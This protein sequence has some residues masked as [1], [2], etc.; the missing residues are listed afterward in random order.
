MIR[1]MSIGMK[2]F[3]AMMA[4]SIIPVIIISILVGIQVTSLINSMAVSIQQTHDDMTTE[5][6]GANLQGSA[7]SAASAMDSFLKERIRDVQE[8]AVSPVVSEATSTAMIIVRSEQLT[9]KSV[10]EIETL[11]KDKRAILM[12]SQYTRFL[13]GLLER[14]PEFSE[15]F[16]TDENGF[17]VSYSNP[18]SD[19]VQSDEVWWQKA[20]QEGSYV[21]QVSYDE[22]SQ[23]YSVEIA[24]R[25]N[26]RKVDG[27]L[28]APLGVMK[29][30]LNVTEF[31]KIA[32]SS[33]SHLKQG[34][35]IVFTRDGYTVIDTGSSDDSAIMSDAGNVLKRSWNTAAEILS[36]G[37]SG[38]LF[39]QKS[40]AGESIDLGYASTAGE[41]Y[42]NLPGF[43]GPQWYVVIQQPTSVSQASLARLKDEVQRIEGFRNNMMQ[44]FV[45]LILV[46]TLI[47]VFLS[48]RISQGIV[49]PI[50]N[51]VGL[52]QRFS[53]GDMD[54]DIPV[55]H[56]NEIGFLERA[57]S[58]MVVQ[59]RQMLQAERT[60]REYMENSVQRY[61]GYM[62]KVGAGNLKAA[63]EIDAKGRSENDPLVRLGHNLEAMTQNLRKTILQI[64]EASANLAAAST[65]ILAA[66]TQQ[67]SGAAEQ[68]AAISQTTTTV[69]EVK[70]IAEQSS[71]RAN[72]VVNA[73]KRTEMVSI[74]GQRSVQNT[75]ESMSQ[76][77]G[78]VEGIAENILALSEQTQQIGEII[79]T[80]NE[81]A[82]QSNMLALNAS[83][84]AARAGEHGKGFAVVA[85]EV[86]SL[87]EQSRSATEQ[88]K[89][90]LSEIQKATN[91]TVMATEEGTKGVD[92][93]VSLAAQAQA[94]LE[95]LSNVIN[96]ASSSARQMAASGQQQATGV[97]QVVLAMRNINQATIQSLASTRQA[98]KAA[99]NLNELSSQ[100]NSMV[101][102]YEL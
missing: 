38:F 98:E 94:A 56:E 36:L 39:D 79:A 66:T 69:D 16:F 21:G 22:S 49:R 80:V 34:K 76:I 86:R 54:V 100:L 25:F 19:F 64:R 53:Q 45:V 1:R 67:A 47:A 102:R 9:K 46:F 13:Q 51:L 81:I 77:K 24:V 57:F 90:I 63:I 42:Y 28:G 55:V 87:A 33:V 15:V 35:V 23:V 96:E 73:A 27:S 58:Q 50:Q 93:G 7:E 85:A 84:E 89:S 72:E 26:A 2:I 8:W 60:E 43:M 92:H 65:E 20:W 68:S 62:Q 99:Q 32:E 83:V 30:V 44:T 48:S 74:E 12:D 101:S 18:T 52:G 10:E 11:R 41:D 29:A 5:V 14:N 40:I 4:L 91:A 71:V 37:K 78:R 6:V 82:S 75:I 61:L 97:E 59:I 95:Q 17:I 70:V 88:V 31:R 3:A